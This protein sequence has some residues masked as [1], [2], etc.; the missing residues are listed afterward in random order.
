MGTQCFEKSHV[1]PAFIGEY[2]Q[3]QLLQ[4]RYGARKSMFVVG[5]VYCGGVIIHWATIE[6]KHLL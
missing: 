3:E 1:V 5:L 2:R 4:V 6:I